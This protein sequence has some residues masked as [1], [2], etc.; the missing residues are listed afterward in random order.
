MHGKLGFL[1]L[2]H[3]ITLA[4]Y[5]SLFHHY[6]PGSSNPSKPPGTPTR[7]ARSKSTPPGTPAR[8]PPR[9]W[10]PR[11]GSSCL[12]K[13]L[14]DL[15]P[16]PLSLF[17]YRSFVDAH[18]FVVVSFTL[19]SSNGALFGGR[20]CPPLL[21]ASVCGRAGGGT[22]LGASSPPPQQQQQQ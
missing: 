17:L 6:N 5:L 21:Q 18:P 7:S 1:L 16:L 20:H 11:L 19:F 2:A 3:S 8:S 14:R 13:H 4:P 15:V 22:F 10:H 9:A 12:P